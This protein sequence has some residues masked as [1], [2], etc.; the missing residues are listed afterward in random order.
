MPGTAPT[1][2]DSPMVPSEADGAGATGSLG[3]EPRAGEEGP[4]PATPPP[5]PGVSAPA[6]TRASSSPVTR[7]MR[8]LLMGA[9]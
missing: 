4:P 2:A 8:K 6:R 9:T 7:Q 3:P 1:V 5:W